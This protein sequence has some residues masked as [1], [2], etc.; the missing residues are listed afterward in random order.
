MP[1]YAF[2]DITPV[3]H[4]SAFVHETAVLIGD[5]FIGDGCFVG[6]GAVLR[7]DISRIEMM[8]GSNVQDTCVVHSY[9]GKD[10]VIEENGHVGHGA[11]VHGC[12]VGRNAL[13]GMNAVLMDDVVVG[14]DCIVGATSF[15]REGTTLPGRTLWAG[16]PARQIRELGDR[17]VEWKTQG[18]RIYQ[19]L[20]TRHSESERR[21]TPLT[22][23]DDA[24]LS[25]RVPDVGYVTKDAFNDS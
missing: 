22:M 4:P 10:V 8:R 18:T 24:R 12:T 1:C 16:T 19:H 15:V 17:E 21:V 6:P 20:A 11:V 25:Q 9:P 5:V 14:P 7:G 3:V 2:E 13:I 23:A